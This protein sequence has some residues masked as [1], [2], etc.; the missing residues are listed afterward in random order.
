MSTS[1]WRLAQDHVKPGLMFIGTEFG[2]FMTQD[3]GKI[4]GQVIRYVDDIDPRHPDSTREN[5]L[6]AQLGRGFS[7]SM[8]THR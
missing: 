1:V 5:D 3:A 6:V 7:C 2:V 4:M 8:I